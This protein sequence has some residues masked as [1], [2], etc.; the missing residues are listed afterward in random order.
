M[1]VNFMR[2]KP[3]TKL[4]SKTETSPAAA[5]ATKGILNPGRV[6]TGRLNR[7][8]RGKIT[9]EGRDK[10][11]KTALQNKPWQF[12]TGPRTAEGKAVVASNGRARQK[13]PTSVREA[14]AEARALRGLIQA[15][16]EA[17]EPQ[18]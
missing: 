9:Q 2:N 6:L 7:S 12:S 15:M 8:K 5:P 18:T 10:L 17:R 14:R 3:D 1:G 13:G 11:R 16:R 4:G